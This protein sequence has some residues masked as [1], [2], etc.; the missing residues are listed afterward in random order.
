MYLL[1]PKAKSLE[2]LINSDTSLPLTMWLNKINLKKC[3][4][5][6]LTRARD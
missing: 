5:I 4:G 1:K 2:Q 3:S 6:V